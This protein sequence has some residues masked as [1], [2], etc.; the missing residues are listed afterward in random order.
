MS[1]R[2]LDQQCTVTRP[3]VAAVASALLVEILVSILQ[4]PLRALAPAPVKPTEDRGEHPLGIVPHQ[5]RG[6]LA[7]FQNVVIRGRS[8]D[9]CSACSKRV[10]AAYR[11]EGWEFVKRAINDTRYIEELSG[12]AE[13]GYQLSY[14]VPVKLLIA[15]RSSEL[16]K[17]RSPK[18]KSQG[19]IILCPVRRNKC[20]KKEVARSWILEASSKHLLGYRVRPIDALVAFIKWRDVVLAYGVIRSLSLA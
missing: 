20:V 13:V 15:L 5:I 19:K 4:H 17:R 12:L 9:S 2:T 11:A 18:W 1:D 16:P 10:V 7:D 3:G 14:L 8:Y 6:F